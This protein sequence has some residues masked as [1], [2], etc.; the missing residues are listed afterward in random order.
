MFKSLTFLLDLL[1][2]L[3]HYKSTFVG[4]SCIGIGLIKRTGFH[5]T[6]LEFCGDVQ[7]W[8]NLGRAFEIFRRSPPG[9]K[10]MMH[11]T[12]V[13][14]KFEWENASLATDAGTC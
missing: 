3:N 12:L 4:F 7:S 9:T 13:A 6:I 2:K 14:T 5:Q 8:L 10:A 1:L 11:T